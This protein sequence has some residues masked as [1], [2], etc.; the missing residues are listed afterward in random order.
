MAIFGFNGEDN[1][2]LDA[3]Q[4][5]QI[6][7][8][9]QVAMDICPIFGNTNTVAD[10]LFRAGINNVT[11][12]IDNAAMA[13]VQ[14][15]EEDTSPYHHACPSLK[16]VPMLVTN[17]GIILKCDTS[18]GRASLIVPVQ[19]RRRVFEIIHYLCHPRQ[20]S[21]RKPIAEK[22]VWNNMRSQI[23]TWTSECLSC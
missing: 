20:N 14:M 21:T 12:G 18:T 6:A 11:L 7:F 3:W 13:N 15:S 22:F 5:R 1:R 8:I 9:S 17:G 16:T 10:C 4:Q 2:S 23:N 19:F